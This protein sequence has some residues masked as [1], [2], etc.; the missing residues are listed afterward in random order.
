MCIVPNSSHQHLR[1]TSICKKMMM[2]FIQQLW[3]HTYLSMNQILEESWLLRFHTDRCKE[4]LQ[5]NKPML[6]MC[7]FSCAVTTYCDSLLVYS[8]TPFN[9]SSYTM[10]NG[11]GRKPWIIPEEYHHATPQTEKDHNLHHHKIHAPP[12]LKTELTWK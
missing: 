5:E 8:V 4:L 2:W 12:S 11:V 6:E 9:C 1:K 7:K 3:P 10:F